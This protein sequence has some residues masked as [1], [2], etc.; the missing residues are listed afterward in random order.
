MW[1]KKEARTQN[2]PPKA[3]EP[4]I[5]DPLRRLGLLDDE[6]VR[7]ML[8]GSRMV[9]VRS[10]RWQKHRGF[11]LLEDCVTVWCES[12]KTS[13]KA[14]RRQ[15][16]CV[17]EV[18]CVR[19]G[20]QSEC[21]RRLADSIPT[22]QCF[23]L[24]FRGGRKSLDL[25][26]S[27]REEAQCWVRG[28]RTLKDRVAN[29]SQKEKL[30]HWIRSYLRRADLNQDG[31]MSYDEVQH[32]L[33][34]INIDL[35]EQY[36]RTLFKKCDRS[37]DNRLDH[38]EIEEFCR[39]LMRRPELDA[40]FRHYSSNG[41]VLSSLELRDF[42]GDQ[43]EGATLAHAQ[44]LIHNFEFNDWAQKNLFMTQNGFTMYMLSNENDI[45][46]PD[47]KRVYQ[48]MSRPLAHYY[49]S[50]S[51]NTYLTKDQV[52][53]ESS[54]EPYIR[55]LNEGC[56]CVEL[57]CWDGDKGEPMIYH[58]HTLTSKVSLKEVIET[59][60]QYA[61]KVSPYP[62]I[63]S[64]ENHCS[65]EQ[66]AVMAQHLRS[67]LGSA[68]LTKPLSDQT[69]N[70][71]PSPEELKG[72]ILVKAKKM[73]SPMAKI[74]SSA[75][76]SSSL[77]EEVVGSSKNSSKK[78]I[79][80]PVSSPK[81]SPEL[82]ALVVYCCSV[83]FPGFE[84]ASQKPPSEMSSFSE[85]EALKHIKDS[86]KLFV[87]HNTRQLSR[88][89]PS[90][91][92]L[93]SSN[94]NPQDMWNGGCQMVALNFQT[95]GEQMDLNRGRFLPNGRC[96]YVLKPDFLCQPNSNFNPENTGG[97]PGHIPTQ[98]TI[99]VIS[100][101]QLPKINTDK[102]NSIV[103]PQVWVEIHGVSIDNARAKTHRVNNNGFNPRWDCTLSFQL[104]VPDLALVRFVV[105]DHDHTSK[106]DF[107]G[108]FTLPFNSLRT[109]YRHIHLLKAD[110]SS[111]SPATLFIHVKVKRRGVPIKTVSERMG[112]V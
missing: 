85:N 66:Q 49:I 87:R 15:P 79:G 72:R 81:M 11:R 95:P 104:Q 82:S 69:L 56:R 99:R 4:K 76:F 30:D 64:L 50:C 63:L 89:Y 110:G 37:H 53:G 102:R 7:V 96:G 84:A 5:A 65:V 18:E 2:E 31:K 83:P 71:L 19:E 77:D 23:T 33:Q 40:V 61:F 93:Q 98:L 44:K 58:G 27:S 24:V 48:D 36:A 111:L 51:H 22:S 106:N 6:D 100:A 28:I 21:L 35:N 29:M 101:Q 105:E 107:V 97:G 70:Q 54:T 25:C 52:T 8:Q 38:V 9:K 39:E 47:H 57:D 46:N 32:L 109:G 45:F 1:R 67:I 59:I 14:K 91:Q 20:C 80:K 17:T 73:I 43:G 55:A 78:D 42:L 94:Y 108:Q 88:I 3:G 74:G 90:G 10:P 60:A 86:G 16:F 41:Y 62:L 13:R 103:D 68:L 112:H 75:S 92:R 34:M 12:S 26:C